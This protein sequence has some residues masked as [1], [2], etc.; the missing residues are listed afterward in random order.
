MTTETKESKARLYKHTLGSAKYGFGI[1]TT[2]DGRKDDS[3]NGREAHFIVGLGQRFG[4]YATKNPVEI[5]LLDKEVEAKHPNIF[6]DSGEREVSEDAL[7]PVAA[8]TAKIRKELLMEMRQKELDATNPERDMGESVQGKLNPSS[9][10]SIA[11]VAAGGDA[12]TL[13]ARLVQLTNKPGA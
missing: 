11:P 2:S 7:N 8:L 10:T 5:A 12:S 3:V 4:R 13:A 9:T 1:L 6:I